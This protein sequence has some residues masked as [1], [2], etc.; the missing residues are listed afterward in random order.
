[1][2][3]N[4]KDSIDFKRSVGRPSVHSSNADKQKAYRE[5]LKGKA[6]VSRTFNIT[7]SNIDKIEAFIDSKH[8]GAGQISKFQAE[9][10]SSIINRALEQFFRKR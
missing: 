6:L 3:T 4:D 8:T 9:D 2:D 1:M 10:Y 5:R 7:L